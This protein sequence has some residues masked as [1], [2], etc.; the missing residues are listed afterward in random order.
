MIPTVAKRLDLRSVVMNTGR[1]LLRKAPLVLPVL[2]VTLL[3][4]SGDDAPVI[5]GEVTFSK[6]IAPILQH[7]CQNY[8]QPL[9]CA[10]VADHLQGSQTVGALHQR[11]HRSARQ[12]GRHASVVH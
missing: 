1:S 10:D 4:A 2:G 3:F 12:T 6:D 11:T 8:H 7:S 5:K 9:D